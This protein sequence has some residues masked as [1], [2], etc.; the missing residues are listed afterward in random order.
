MF[1][2]PY[3]EFKTRQIDFHQRAAHFRLVRSLEIPNNVVSRV[4]NAV[5]KILI[6]SG[7][8]LILSSEPVL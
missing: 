6:I 8:Q 3:L 4:L 2:D 5:G 1:T 7:E